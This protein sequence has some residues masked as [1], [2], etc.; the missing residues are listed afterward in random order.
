MKYMQIS[1]LTMDE[2]ELMVKTIDKWVRFHF[3]LYGLKRDTSFNARANGG[4]AQIRVKVYPEV[5]D[6]IKSGAM[7]EI[8][9]LLG[10]DIQFHVEHITKDFQV[11][12]LSTCE[13][14]L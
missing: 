2:A 1:A 3:N 13:V 12:D 7:S 11:L 8:V 14:E 6:Y 4:R 9:N 10:K 5:W